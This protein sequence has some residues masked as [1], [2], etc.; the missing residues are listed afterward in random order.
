MYLLSVN[1]SKPSCPPSRPM[2]RCLTPPN[3]AA[4]SETRPRFKPTFPSPALRRRA[5]RG[6]DHGCRRTPQVV[7]G[8]I[9]RRYRVGL[10]VK[11]TI[12]AAG[13]RISSRKSAASAETSVSTV[14]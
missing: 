6:T 10:V 2:P 1:S 9:R 3:G 12:G 14:G 5:A 8:V 11:M 13:P 4:G 7:L